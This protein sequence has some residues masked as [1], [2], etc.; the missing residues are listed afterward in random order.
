[1]SNSQSSIDQEPSVKLRALGYNLYMN[2]FLPYPDIIKSV[3][4]L[5]NKRLGK[6]KIEY[7]WPV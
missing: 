5:D 7:Y 1:M 6:P 2:T 3:Q 4:C